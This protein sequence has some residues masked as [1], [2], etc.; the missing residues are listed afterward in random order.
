ML[1]TTNKD[2][3]LLTKLIRRKKKRRKQFHLNKYLYMCIQY[4]NS[5]QINSYIRLLHE[6]GRLSAKTIIF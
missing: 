6:N 5:N 2:A 4:V 3:H 1:G